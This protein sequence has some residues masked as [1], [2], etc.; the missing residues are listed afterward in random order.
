MGRAILTALIYSIALCAAVVRADAAQADALAGKVLILAAASTTDAVEDL[1]REFMRMH[2]QVTLRTSFA[3]SS[4]LARQIEAGAEADLFLSANQQWAEVIDQ[5]GLAARQC[6]LLGNELVIIVPK[7]SK[8]KITRPADLQQAS[9]RHVALAD[10]A[11]VPAGIYA[12]QALEKLGLW[13]SLEKRVTGA[14]DVRQALQYVESGAAE[15]GIVYATDAA[16]SRRVKVVAHIDTKLTEPIHYPLML[17]AAG[18]KNPAA[19]AFYEFM[20]SPQAAKVFQ[21]H[22]F[23]DLAHTPETSQTRD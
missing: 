2:P 21:R 13:T 12:K 4:T 20:Q 15:A 3:A 14:A 7:G 10:V 1:S 8:L 5:R 16:A 23:V 6:Q 22:G 9:V 19:V 18:K 11:S 17:L